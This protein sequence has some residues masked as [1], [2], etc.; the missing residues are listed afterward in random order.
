MRKLSQL[1]D[2]KLTSN[3]CAETYPT[4]TQLLW[5]AFSEAQ[6]KQKDSSFICCT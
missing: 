3:V 1:I 4:V 6:L 5:E 2:L